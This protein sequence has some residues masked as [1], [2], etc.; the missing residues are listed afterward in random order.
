[1]KF[2]LMGGLVVERGVTEFINESYIS[3]ASGNERAGPY[4]YEDT[5]LA[6]VALWKAVASF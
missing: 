6:I 5:A 3:E 2:G 1:M 4:S